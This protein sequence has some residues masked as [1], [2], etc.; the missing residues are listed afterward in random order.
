M[1]S[2]A[3]WAPEASPAFWINRTSRAL[4]RHFDDSLRPHGFAM[5]HL[6]VL[7]ALLRTPALSQTQLARVANVEQ[8]TMAE[9]LNRL[10]RDGVVE[11][12]PNPE[13]RRGSLVSLT[14]KARARFPQGRAAL[15]ESE[16][17]A[18][19]GLSTK[20]RALLCS[21]LERVMKNLEAVES[22]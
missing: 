6:P 21:L 18:M 13:D 17:V 19:A 5:S 7:G 14:R 10:E 9:L 8:P 3:T 20:E 15:M 22:T 12:K 16:Q 2:E 4:T 11:R 1:Q